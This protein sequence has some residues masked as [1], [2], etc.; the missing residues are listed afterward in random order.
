MKAKGI[1]KVTVDEL[2]RM[3]QNGFLHMENLFKSELKSGLAEHT[4][5]ILEEIRRLNADVKDVKTTLTPTVGI[6]A[7]HE[8]KIHALESRV[9]YVEQKMGI[10]RLRR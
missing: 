10:V 6:V 8:Q 1:K 4:G 3:T 2:A 5:V 7:E 9:G